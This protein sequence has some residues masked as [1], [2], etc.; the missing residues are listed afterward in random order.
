LKVPT[1]M[2][3]ARRTLAAKNAIVCAFIQLTY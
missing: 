2:R 3:L 1:M